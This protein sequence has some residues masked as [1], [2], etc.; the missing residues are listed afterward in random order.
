MKNLKNFINNTSKLDL[1]FFIILFG[2]ILFDCLKFLQK[3][4]FI[5]PILIIISCSTPK[6]VIEQQEIKFEQ[7]SIEKLDS[8]CI[9]DTLS[10]NLNLWHKLELRD[11]ESKIV[12]IRYMYIK[13]SDLIYIIDNNRV[14][15]R[16]IKQ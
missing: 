6:Q 10:S 14:F 4:I 8:I 2:L 5:I 9:T 13:N 3:L 11:Y 15:K 1:W 12:T 16:Y 7:Y